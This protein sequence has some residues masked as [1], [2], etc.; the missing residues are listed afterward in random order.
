M[1]GPLIATLTRMSGYAVAAAVAASGLL[2]FI[3]TMGLRRLIAPHAPS[4]AKGTTYESGV[5]PVGR[6]WAQSQ[7]R[8]V[9]FAFLYVVFAVD[10]IYLFPWALAIRMPGLGL[11]SLV[12]I[13]LFIGILALG[14]VHAARRGL[15]RWP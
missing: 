14:L 12:E 3:A 4:A 15:L 9:A 11:R 10:A 2:L 1:A 13:A 8:Y 7:I 5:D 6:G